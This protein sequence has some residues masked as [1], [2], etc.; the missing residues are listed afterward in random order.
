MKKLFLMLT[1]LL[2]VAVVG[3]QS[4]EEIVKKYSQANMLD[5]V[6]SLKTIKITGSMD[7]MGQAIPVEIW[8]KNPDKIKSVTSVN[9]QEIIQAFDGVKG[10]SVNPMMGSSEPVEMS[11]DDAKQIQRNNMFQNYMVNY[12]KNGQ[13]TLEGE[14]SVNGTPAHKVKAT[15][16]GG[17]T[18]NMF[19]DKTSNLLV[20]TSATVNSQGMEVVVDSYP[21]DY[22]EVSGLFL[23]MKTKTSLQG[24]EF[25]Q[26]YSKVEV[27]IPME[28]S[29]FKLK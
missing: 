17:M 4:L 1:C 29:I 24:M 16:E 15:L 3:A 2:A 7:M 13:L 21:S 20:K 9:G 19:I 26:T 11:A 18:L 14:E 5:K 23:P 28:D 6:G 25:V 10:Y 12:L 27:N 8:M 22:K